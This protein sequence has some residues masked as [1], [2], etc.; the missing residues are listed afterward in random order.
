MR[1]NGR[2]DDEMVTLVDVSRETGINLRTLQVAAQTK[3]LWA[4]KQGRDWFTTPAALRKW[5]SDPTKRRP[6][7]TRP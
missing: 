5:E 2:K 6:R 3:R 1:R 7:K 4:K